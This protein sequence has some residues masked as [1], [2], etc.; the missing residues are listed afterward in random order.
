MKTSEEKYKDNCQKLL[1]K[2][3]SAAEMGGVAHRRKENHTDWDPGPWKH[4]LVCMV[5]G[6]EN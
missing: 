5:F 4:E 1:E 2:E 6:D 3:Q